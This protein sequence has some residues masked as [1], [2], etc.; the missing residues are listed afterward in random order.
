METN[1]CI[2]IYNGVNRSIRGQAGVMIH[3][4]IKNTITNYTYWSKRT[5]KVKL[6]I[7]R[8]KL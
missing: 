7:G 1:N 3:I 2:V 6:N 5:I 8:G 4:S